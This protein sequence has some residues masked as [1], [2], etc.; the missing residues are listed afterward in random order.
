VAG[1]CFVS[2]VW[3]V[4]GLLVMCDRSRY[5]SYMQQVSDFVSFLTCH[6]YAIYMGHV[7]GLSVS[8]DRTVVFQLCLTGQWFIIFMLQVVGFSSI[9]MGQWF[10]SYG[11]PLDAP[12][13][14]ESSRCQCL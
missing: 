3:Q 8:C 9:L 14:R 12:V 11:F 2:Y 13:S 1:H 7:G 6:W 5:F 10:F 4:I